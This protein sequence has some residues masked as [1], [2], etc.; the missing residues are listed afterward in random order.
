MKKLVLL[1]FLS[2]CGGSSLPQYNKLES[3]RVLAI[4]SSSPE[5]SPGATVTITPVI[6]DVTGGG[7]S[8][9]YNADT[10]IDPGVAY[11]AVP[12][13]EGLT[14][15]VSIAA[16]AAVTGL[17]SPQYTAAVTSTFS[18]T[19]PATILDG[20]STV[21][22]LLGVNYL[23]VIKI[24]A[25]DGT[26]VSA[27]KRILAST[28]PT[29][30]NNPSITRVEANGSTVV[31]TLFHSWVSLQP[32]FGAGSAE[33][34]TAILPDGSTRTVTEVLTTTWFISSGSLG[35]TRTEGTAT[36]GYSPP[37]GIPAV[38]LVAVT[39]D[40]RGGEDA[41]VFLLQ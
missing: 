30:N 34:Y 6:S 18:V 12:S 38:S 35:A 33:S 14:S 41:K 21:Q 26:S 23:V 8:L 19:V 4:L 22:Q 10:C 11:G 31:G 2:G 28:N 27:F 20:Y 17:S 1:L 39:R 25:S 24:T 37:V 29:K 13:C 5:V 16:N 15:R 32:I 3:L 36:L 40:G 9:T 7:R